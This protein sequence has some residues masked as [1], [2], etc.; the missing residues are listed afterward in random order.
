[1]KMTNRQVETLLVKLIR[2]LWFVKNQE[3]VHNTERALLHLTSSTFVYTWAL[4]F[5]V[6]LGQQG[7]MRHV[8]AG[9]IVLVVVG[10]WE[11]Y[12]MSQGQTLK[13]GLS[14]ILSWIIGCVVSAFMLLGVMNLG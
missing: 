10:I 6:A 13:K 7:I 3:D 2:K 11:I 4:F 5:S 8:V 9:L 1:M 14:D 12:N